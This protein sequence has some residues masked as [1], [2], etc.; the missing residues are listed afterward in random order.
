M[1]SH[2]RGLSMLGSL[3]VAAGLFGAVAV[4]PD[5]SVVKTRR[6]PLGRDGKPNLTAPAPRMPDGKPDFSGIW[7]TIRVPCE[8]SPAGAIFGCTDVPLG[9]SIG[10]FDVTATGSQDGQAGTTEKL[11]YRPGVEE[12]V[13]RNLAENRKDDTTTSCIPISPD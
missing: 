3:V 1:T 4:E 13:N 5:R 10:L 2:K 6:A 8:G 12:Q 11:P 7:N 9:V